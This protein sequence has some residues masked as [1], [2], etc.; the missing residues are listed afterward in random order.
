MSS[1]NDTFEI[2][3]TLDDQNFKRLDQFL[4]HKL[5]DYSRTLLK[6]L[7]ER[8]QIYA[9]N[10]KKIELKKMP[11]VGTEIIVEIPPPLPT[12]IVPQNIPLEI[13]Y[14]DEHLII[15]NKEQG[16][17][18]HPGA[19]N[20]DHTLVNAILYHCPDLKGVGNEKRPGIVHRLDKGTSGVMVVAKSHEAHEK[21][22]E[23]FSTHN[24][25]RVYEALILG[26]N[27]PKMMK[28]ESMIARH[29][30]DR[31]KMTSQVQFGKKAITNF[32]VLEYFKNFTHVEL[33][34]E[35]GRTHQ[36]RV[37]LSEVLKSPILR[38]ELYG[39]I[40]EEE[41]LYPPAILKI[42]KNF[43]Y[44]LLHAKILGFDHPITNQKLYFEK[45]PPAIFQEVLK[46]LKA[47]NDTRL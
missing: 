1:E 29:S 22:V 12:A 11:A 47:S 33:K 6:K 30:R 26:H 25:E 13:L 35:T 3:I 28:I 37:H 2:V 23:K 9:T 20:Y 42:L 18:V 39:R 19:G 7:F 38:D 15:I 40:N 45:A 34:L 36:I 4:A 8:D 27:V 46:L 32:K 44:P 31:L 41:K 5:P 21:L 24:I 14:E 10:G 17:V 43:S 16:L